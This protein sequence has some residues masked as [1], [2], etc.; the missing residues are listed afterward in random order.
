MR[1]LLTW[2]L[3]AF[4]PA[5]VGAPFPAPAYYR[6]LSKPAWAPPSWLFAPVWTLLYALIGTA[7]WLVARDPRPG[8]RPALALWGV[9][10]A[11]NAAWTPIFFGLRARGL[12]LGEIVVMWLAVIATTVAFFKRRVS[13]GVLLL[14]YLSWVTFATLLTAAIWRRNP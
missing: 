2:L 1:R 5:A 14:P 9:Q 7:A 8:A 10:L 11:L 4:L 6:G 13:A 3:A 12:A